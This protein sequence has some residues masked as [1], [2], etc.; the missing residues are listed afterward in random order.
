MD[1]HEET[2]DTELHQ[3][4]PRSIPGMV[5]YIVILFVLA[6]FSFLA[7]SAIYLMAFYDACSLG[8]L[9]T[10]IKTLQGA[11]G[12][13]VWAYI[14]A[15]VVP[16]LLVLGIYS[17]LY[18]FYRKKKRIRA[19]HWTLIGAGVFG[20][21]FGSV[22]LT[23]AWNYMGISEYIALV[24]DTS[25]VIDESYVDP[26][27]VEISRPAKKKNLILLFLESMENTWGDPSI[28]GVSEVNLI[29]EL[30]SYSLAHGENFGDG[31]SLNGA[32][33]L[34][35]SNWTAASLF[36]N[37]SATPLKVPL[38]SAALSDEHT[39]FPGVTALG[40]ILEVDGYTQAFLC[41]SDAAFGGRKAYFSAHGDFDFYDLNYYNA[42]PKEDPHHMDFDGFWGFNDQNLFSFAR[43][44]LKGMS[45]DY[46]AKGTPF[47]FSTLTVD[48][49]FP[50][51]N[52]CPLCKSEHSH[53]YANVYSCSSR[54]VTDFLS[55]FYDSGELPKETTSNTVT[56][57]LGDHKSMTNNPP[58]EIPE[59]Y[60]R[61]TFVS[62]FNAFASRQSLAPRRYSSL[63][64]FPTILSALGYSIEGE[65]LGLGVNL[66]SSLPTLTEQLGE[67]GI[68]DEIQ[69]SSK[70]LESLLEYDCSDI[71]EVKRTHRYPEA[72]GIETEVKGNEATL[73]LIRPHNVYEEYTAYADI[74]SP[75]GTITVK[76]KAKD[77]DFFASKTLEKGHYVASFYLE[78]KSKNRYSLG[79]TEFD[80]S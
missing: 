38:T 65:R 10:Q 80:I 11:A 67:K 37:T 6:L 52:P 8:M 42:F 58:A 71:E 55:W 48:T 79:E 49:H 41:G 59:G 31:A 44:I 36:A 45:D 19:I 53:P 34:E 54:Q 47:H 16:T 46:I 33:P 14:A 77:R 61:D 29:P 78:G 17:F 69:K 20:L 72:R 66:F 57:V 28:G 62:Y 23:S 2:I 39:Y 21:A 76:L 27:S 22:S 9:F 68:N 56:V 1:A 40:D 50:E 70:V 3:P 4:E 64:S 73:R 5:R 24:S 26:Y 63:D 60:S 13:T 75:Q 74:L 30:S 18:F 25:E 7:F 12:G 15:A 32:I 51:G 35:F 43:E